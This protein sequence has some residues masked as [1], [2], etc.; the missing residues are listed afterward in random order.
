MPMLSYPTS[1]ISVNAYNWYSGIVDGLRERFEVCSG[2]STKWPSSSYVWDSGT[3]TD[4]TLSGSDII[5]EDTAATGHF[6]GL[7]WEHGGVKRWTSFSGFYNSVELDGA[8][9]SYKIVIFPLDEGTPPASV[10]ADPNLGL[11]Y[12]ITD[13]TDDTVTITDDGRMELNGLD[14]SDYIGW[15]YQI[16]RQGTVGGTQAGYGWVDRYPH[17]ANDTEKDYGIIVSSTTTTITDDRSDPE[18]ETNPDKWQV[19]KDWTVNEFAGTHDVMCKVSGR[20]RRLPITANTIDTLTFASPGAAP[21]TSERYW[22]VPTDAWFRPEYAILFDRN[23]NRHGGYFWRPYQTASAGPSRWYPVPAVPTADATFASPY[24]HHPDNDVLTGY[25][26]P[27]ETIT[28]E[29]GQGAAA[30][31]ETVINIFDLDATTPYDD[32]CLQA[33]NMFNPYFPGRS[34]RGWQYSTTAKR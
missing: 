18:T 33:D 20:W 9:G 5:I 29:Q 7:G 16:I 23:V 31:E 2:G 27:N 26:I 25:P 30:C 28:L 15:G 10:L 12:N 19:P 34:V 21:T 13:N 8:P 17:K 3:I 14:L 24:S 1:L 32:H 11:V 6:A 22:I 4:V